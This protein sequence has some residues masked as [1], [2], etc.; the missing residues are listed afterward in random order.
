MS[1]KLKIL[2]ASIYC[3]LFIV[4]PIYL[5]NMNY[6]LMVFFLFYLPYIMLYFFG[7]VKVDKPFVKY[8]ITNFIFTTILE[9]VSLW[10]DI[11]NFSNNADM[12]WGID[13]F[14]APIEE[15][16]YWNGAGLFVVGLYYWFVGR[17]R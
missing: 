2:I 1:L 17:V 9:Y 8:L 10:A 16:F 7:K 13:I 12:F 15:F 4:A 11:W 6:G 3:A 5:I 14:G